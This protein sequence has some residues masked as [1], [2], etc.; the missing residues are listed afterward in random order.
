[1]TTR[2]LVVKSYKRLIVKTAKLTGE[3]RERK[4]MIA[5]LIGKTE[6]EK[7]KEKELYFYS[8]LEALMAEKGLSIAELSER[9]GVAQSTKL[10]GFY[11]GSPI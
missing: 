7:E 11:F 9:T 5:T 10:N 1:M 2:R 8:N 4:N 6:Y 3:H